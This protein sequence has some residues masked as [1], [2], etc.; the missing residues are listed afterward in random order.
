[1]KKHRQVFLR[2]ENRLLRLALEQATQNQ[3]RIN[4]EQVRQRF[5]PSWTADQLK[6][7]YKNVRQR[8]K[9]CLFISKL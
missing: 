2:S 5:L 3:S 1:M 4:W 8:C 7:R 9:V 6:V